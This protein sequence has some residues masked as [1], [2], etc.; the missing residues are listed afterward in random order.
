M[1]LICNSAVLATLM[2]FAF[3]QNANAVTLNGVKY[4]YDEL[5]S[6]PVGSTERS[7]YMK[8][9]KDAAVA[10]LSSCGSNCKELA[11]QINES[12]D[13]PFKRCKDGSGSFPNSCSAINTEV[14]RISSSSSTST[15]A[16]ATPTTVAADPIQRA[17]LSDKNL[18]R[19]CN[20]AKEKVR[21]NNPAVKAKTAS[22]Q[23]GP[24]DKSGTAKIENKAYRLL[25]E[26]A[27]SACKKQSAQ[28]QIENMAC[29]PCYVSAGTI[30]PAINTDSVEVDGMLDAVKAGNGGIEQISATFEKTFGLSYREFSDLYCDSVNGKGDPKVLRTTQKTLDSTQIFRRKFEALNDKGNATRKS[31]KSCALSATREEMLDNGDGSHQVGRCTSPG[32]GKTLRGGNDIECADKVLDLT[33][34]RDLVFLNQHPD[35]VYVY[36]PGSSS[37]LPGCYNVKSIDTAKLSLELESITSA[38][39]AYIPRKYNYAN[40]NQRLEFRAHVCRSKTSTAD[41]ALYNELVPSA[42]GRRGGAV[43]Q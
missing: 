39:P 35:L 40:N 18:E 26:L 12:A 19:E 14:T 20:A 34:S 10:A 6:K 23:A 7:S 27:V 28:F 16:A 32:D 2:C 37:A 24:N 22:D 30:V 33:N 41:D 8:S 36:A 42:S 25:S 43:S 29:G 9:F 13:S 1:K 21:N 4:T 15:A 5:M 17:Q 38:V 31:I 11:K 3:L